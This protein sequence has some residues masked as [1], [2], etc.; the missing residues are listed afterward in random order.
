M[1]STLAWR[2]REREVC[3]LAQSEKE[4]ETGTLTG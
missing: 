1:V 3:Y 2:E 4:E